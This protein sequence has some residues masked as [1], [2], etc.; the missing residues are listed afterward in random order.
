MLPIL[1]K[2]LAIV[3]CGEKIFFTDTAR[4][5]RV[6]KPTT[7][8]LD[9]QLNRSFVN[10]T[11]FGS[12]GE[13]MSGQGGDHLFLAPPPLDCLTDYILDKGLRGLFQKTN[14]LAAYQQR[15]PYTKLLAKSV[16]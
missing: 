11:G 1:A 14:E 3:E 13:F 12:N 16:R 9:Y 10:Y 2:Y 4:V 6:N 5:A 15:I 7:F 8:M